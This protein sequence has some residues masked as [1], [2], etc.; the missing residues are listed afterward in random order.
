MSILAGKPVVAS[1]SSF[2]YSRSALIANFTG[3][4]NIDKYIENP[5]I[6][7]VVLGRKHLTELFV[8]VMIRSVEA[9]GGPLEAGED[10]P[11][12]RVSPK[13]TAKM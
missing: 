7:S 1:W 4:G 9:G 13:G 10:P 2:T 3:G 12:L 8:V 11:N 5:L 6:F